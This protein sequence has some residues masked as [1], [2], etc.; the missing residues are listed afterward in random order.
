MTECSMTECSMARGGESPPHVKT[1]TV[2][3]DTANSRTYPLQPYHRRE[4][5]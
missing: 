5:P 4:H 1:P 2:C 3:Y